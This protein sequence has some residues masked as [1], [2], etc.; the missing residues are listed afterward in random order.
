M[1]VSSTFGEQPALEGTRLEELICEG[2]E[3]RGESVSS[4]NVV[5]LRA[6][7]RWWRLSIDAGTIHWRQEDATPQPWS[8][9]EEGWNYP[10]TD[11]GRDE[12]LIGFII[13]ALRTEGHGF[14]VQVEIEFTNG[15]TFLLVGT[16]DT[17]TYRIA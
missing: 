11:V 4:A 3:H 13:S 7:S 5:F 15:K 1:G 12:G 14:N 9:E 8:V 2:F 6:R 10:H 16:V 17:T